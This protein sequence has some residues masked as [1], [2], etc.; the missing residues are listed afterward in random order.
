MVPNQNADIEVLCR[1]GGFM[2]SWIHPKRIIATLA[3]AMAMSALMPVMP[4]Y[5]LISRIMSVALNEYS[6][7]RTRLMPSR[8]SRS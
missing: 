8:R 6:I 3:P 2:R 5:M 7:H 1:P 4:E